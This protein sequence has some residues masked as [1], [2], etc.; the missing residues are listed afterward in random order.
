M[1]VSRMT[2]D[3]LLRRSANAYPSKT[4]I[5]DGD[6]RLTF[7]EFDAE[8]DA[9]AAALAALGVTKG[10]RVAALFFNQWQFQLTYFATLRLGALIVP[11]NNRLVA[12]EIA[13]QLTDA[14]AKVLVYA[15]EFDDVAVELRDQVGVEHCIGAATTAGPISG[16]RL[17]ELLATH[18]G[19]RAELTDAVGHEDPSGIWYTS[20]TTGVPKGAVVTHASGLWAAVALAL[21]TRMNHDSRVLAVAPMFHRGPMET[22]HVAA[23]LLGT[24]QALLPTFTPAGLLASLQEHRATH[25]FIVPAMTFGVLSLPDRGDYDLSSVECW[26]TASAHFPEEYRVRLERETTLRPG[27]IFNAYGITESLLIGT[28]TPEQAVA[29]PGSVGLPVVGCRVRILDTT[30]ADLPANSVGEITVSTPAVASTYASRPDAWAAVAFEEDG[31]QWYRSGDLGYLDADG[32]I[33]IVDRAKDMVVSGG[34]NVYSA[35]VER[36]L[37]RHPDVADA[38]VVGAPD[39]RWGEA[40]TAFVVR[41]PGSELGA[42]ELTTFCRRHLAGYKLPRVV[43]FMDVLPRNSFGKVQKAP[44]R[45]RAAAATAIRVEA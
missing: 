16:I 42:D 32:Y 44:L 13:F 11:I 20:G 30:G 34:E 26:L 31:V 22:V 35:E 25:A 36:I 37:L 10:D 17:D 3:G 33:Y 15:A 14:R 19:G 38:A 5:I 45:E 21:A 40:V 8:V 1:N 9:F 28:L 39:A 12:E 43:H 29:H 41:R 24:T 23:F 2:I 18:R 27:S 4:A 6:L 7:A